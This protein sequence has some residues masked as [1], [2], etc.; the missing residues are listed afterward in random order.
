LS[1]KLFILYIYLKFAPKDND[2]GSTLG[3]LI[4]KAIGRTP[5]NAPSVLYDNSESNL[6]FKLAQEKNTQT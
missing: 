6:K 4:L 1:A 2:P 5:T 3:G